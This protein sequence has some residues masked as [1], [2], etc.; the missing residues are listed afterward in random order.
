MVTIL[1]GAALLGYLAAGVLQTASFARGRAEVPRGTVALIGAAAL[2]QL[3]ALIAFGIWFGELP[4]VGLGPSLSS[5]TFLIAVFLLF[6]TVATDTRPVGLVLLPVIVVLLGA[7]LV[8]GIQPSGE[9]L[10]FSGAWFSFHV[11]L[12]FVGVAGFAF[13]FAAG[14]LYLLQF[15][16]LKSKRFGR[17]FRFFPALHTLDLMG[18]RSAVVGFCA[19]SA[20]LALG[21]AWTIRFHGTFAMSDPQVIWGAITWLAFAGVLGARSGGAG[22]SR[23]AARVSVWGFAFVVLAFVVLR[24]A[25]AG[26]AGFL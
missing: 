8:I 13:A 21:W 5:L 14:L 2:V 1:H 25:Q 12:A 17:I 4:L 10:A 23:R 11:V 16:E 9:P 24:L 19:L 22:S 7:A 6:A 18:R 15:R 3:G 26:G 20:G